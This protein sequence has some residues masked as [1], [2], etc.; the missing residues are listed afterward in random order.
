VIDPPTRPESYFPLDPEDETWTEFWGLILD[1]NRLAKEKNVP[2][3]LIL[4]PLE[5]QVLD[6]G[7]PTIP[8]DV[9]MSNA[10]EAGIPALDLLPA[11]RQACQ[12]KPGG[13]CQLE[14][15]YLFA[16]VWMHPSAYGHER[17]A[18]E[19]ETLVTHG[20]IDER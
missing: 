7:Y 3:I 19:L 8:Q 11:F 13:A 15:R 17:T 9:L 6:E 18:V 16:D 12:E 1:I 4:F 20:L 14:D 2:V 10:A 5:F